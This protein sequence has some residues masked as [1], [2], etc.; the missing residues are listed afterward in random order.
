MLGLSSRFKAQADGQVHEQ[1]QALPYSF[2]FSSSMLKAPS[3]NITTK[4]ASSTLPGSATQQLPVLQPVNLH[5][6]QLTFR[7]A[8][9]VDIIDFSSTYSMHGLELLSYQQSRSCHKYKKVL[10]AGRQ[11]TI[12]A[13]C[14]AP[15]SKHRL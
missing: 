3:A 9:V 7:L 4:H 8:N 14:G 1:V 6:Q 10:A 2:G 11:A 13:D 5:I 15:H 12:H